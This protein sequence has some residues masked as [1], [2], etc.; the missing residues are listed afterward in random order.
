MANRHTVHVSARFGK[1][2]SFGIFTALQR[3]EGR[4]W[5]LAPDRTFL[6]AGEATTLPLS[7]PED[8]A[9]WHA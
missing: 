8:R 1:T 2:L 9:C 4:L 6:P 7:A 5:T 3:R